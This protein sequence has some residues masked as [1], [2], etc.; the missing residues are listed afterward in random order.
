MGKFINLPHTVIHYIAEKKMTLNKQYS[1]TSQI[2]TQYLK[3]SYLFYYTSIRSQAFNNKN[4][5][6]RSTELAHYVFKK[7][8]NNAFLYKT[9]LTLFSVPP[10]LSPLRS[11][12]DSPT[13]NCSEDYYHSKIKKQNP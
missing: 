13:F 12:L 5:K 6:C 7:K 8:V 11:T 10:M 2:K 4:N 9:Q 1:H 3:D